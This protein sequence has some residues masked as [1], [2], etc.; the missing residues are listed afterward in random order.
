MAALL[1]PAAL[2]CQV[3]PLPS[4]EY[5]RSVWRTA[6]GLPEATVQSLAETR[7]GILW[8]G[9]TGGLA[10]FGGAQIR[11]ANAGILQT[12]GVHSIFCLTIDRDQSLWAG[13]EGGGLLHL[14]GSHVDVFSASQGLSDNFVRSIFQDRSGTVWVGTDNG[15]FRM[16]SGFLRRMDGASVPPMAVH[17]ITQD[18]DGNIWAGGSQLISIS[19]AGVAKLHALP[20]LYSKNRVK[21]ILQTSDGTIWVG[22]VAGL[23]RLAGGSFQP[24]PSIHATVRSLLQT[25]DGTLWIGTIG[26]GLWTFRDGKLN[27]LHT[28]GLLPSDTVLTTLQDDAGQIWIGTQAGLV[29]LSRTPVG[30]VPLPRVGDPDFETVSGDAR[31]DVWV[32]AQGLFAIRDNRAMPVQFPGLGQLSIRN[33]FRGR[34]GALWIGTDGSGAYRIDGSSI[35]HLS[36][37]GE[38]TNNFIRGFLQ[39]RDGAVWIATDEGVSRIAGTDIRKFKEASGLAYFSTRYLLEDRSGGVWIGTDR[40]VSYWKDGFQS[41]PAVSALA[42][43][44]VWSILQ[45][46]RNVLWFATRDDGLFRYRDG[47]VEHF[48]ATQGLPSNSIYQLLQDRQGIF[49]L[50]GPDTIASIEEAAMDNGFPSIEHPL[51]VRIYSMP[52][53]AEGAQIYGGRQPA[54]LIAA[55]GTVWLPTSRGVAYVRPDQH[56][57]H[58]IAPRAVLHRLTE[59]GRDVP[60]RDGLRI[61]AGIT[62]LTIA[63]GAISLQSQ[64]NKRFRYRLEPLESTWNSTRSDDTA[65]YTNLRA[66]NYRFRVQVFDAAQPD[67]ISEVEIGF[68]KEPYFYQ[69]WWFLALCVLLAAAIVWGVY[70]FRVQQMQTRFRAVLAERSRLAREIHDT[71]IQGCTSISALLE[72]IASQPSPV[73][74]SELLEYARNQARTTIQ[75]ARQAVWGMR[76]EEKK[77]DLLEAVNS[78]AEQTS[79]EH[80]SVVTVKAAAESLPVGTSAAHEILMTVREALYNAVQ[81]SGSK[82]IEMSVGQARGELTVRVEDFGCGFDSEAAVHAQNGHFGLLGMQERMKRLGGRLEIHSALQRGTAIT[83]RIR[84]ATDVRPPL[85]VRNTE[86]ETN[87]VHARGD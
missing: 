72:A 5:T 63:F 10:S 86:G 32:A 82:R 66:G 78:L 19:P 49:W 3:P 1:L 65:T 24:M 28:P 70:R 71:V 47:S 62:R 60:V 77:V 64:L 12:L 59:D 20:G 74:N 46:R 45:D 56:L 36:A 18:R 87:G 15:L 48:T 44:K 76:H 51:S 61:P 37:P 68:I 27:A 39:A 85:I 38:L 9:T 31:G 40:G 8:I 75:E 17:S 33:V 73:A 69:T 81:H 35:R 4:F 13:T 52:F 7:D 25:S 14:R 30:V 83:L 79:R 43:E 2:V 23:Q 11:A 41:N 80:G 21:S 54:G 50:T 42:K 34:D 6:D 26:N 53:G 55:D 16:H 58:G 57:P 84:H 29:R 22:T 67:Q